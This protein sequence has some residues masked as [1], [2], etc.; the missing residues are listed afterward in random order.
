[1]SGGGSLSP[2]QRD[3]RSAGLSDVP[4]A[5]GGGLSVLFGFAHASQAAAS[6]SSIERN[7]RTL[8]LAGLIPSP[9]QSES[10]G[11]QCHAERRSVASGL[12]LACTYGRK[13]SKIIWSARLRARRACSAVRTVQVRSGRPRIRL[14]MNGASA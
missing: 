2:A 3:A 13:P 11:R 7:T 10:P 4:A 12:W 9:I 6:T 5:G 14:V 1:S 8:S